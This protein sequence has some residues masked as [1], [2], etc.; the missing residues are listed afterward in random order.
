[1]IIDHYFNIV[2][3]FLNK[4]TSLINLNKN[5]HAQFLIKHKI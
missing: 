5:V 3:N 1:M 2:C 4:L